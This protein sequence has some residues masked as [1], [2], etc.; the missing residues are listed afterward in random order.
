MRGLFRFL[1]SRRRVWLAFLLCCALFAA[2]FAL[3]EF[4]LRAV[5][6]PALLCL[7]LLAVFGLIG[8]LRE[9]KK[10]QAV[11]EAGKQSPERLPAMLPKPEGPAEEQY[12]AV[13]RELCRSWR[14]DRDEN[15][16]RLTEL[17]ENYT[18]WAHQIKTPIASMRLTL[19]N[20][21]SPLSRRMETELGHIESYVEM[22]MVLVRLDAGH[23]DYVF[24]EQPLDPIVR[25]VVHGFAGEFIL[26]GLSL[27]YEPIDQTVLTDE[28]W[29][30]FV[31]GQLLS[32]ALK[33][34]NEGGVAISMEPEA[35]LCIRDTGIGIAPE[36][37]PRVFEKGYTG[38][39]GRL[40]RRAS[41]VGLYLCRRICEN[42]GHSL[43]LRSE[44]GRGTEAR[45]GLAR[46]A[47]GVE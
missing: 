35:T 16:A 20:E 21:D 36:D 8:L 47:L 13:I 31:I 19:Q 25:E 38:L 28:K 44:P 27:R 3:Y 22:A 17:R 37:L 6:Y 32:N 18:L 41:G 23:T 46:Q 9:R 10:T 4:P 30:S 7:V 42:L 34:T 33:Y 11:S 40:D 39:N 26:R 1:V 14:A 24:R 43:E 45:I 15:A 2:C 12:Q 29:L 5:F